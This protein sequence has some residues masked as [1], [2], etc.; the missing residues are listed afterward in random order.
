[1]K[2][3][4]CA[5]SANCAC[6]VGRELLW[7]F[8]KEM[9]VIFINTIKLPDGSFLQL[10]YAVLQKRP[11]FNV[12]F[13]LIQWSPTFAVWWSG[14]GKGKQGHMSGGLAHMCTQFNFH[15]QWATVHVHTHKVWLASW[16]AIH[17]PAAICM[18]AHYSHS[19]VANRSRPGNGYGP[20]VGDPCFNS[21]VHSL[22][23][24]IIFW[25]QL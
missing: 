9:Y 2:N 21:L 25:V 5:E 16:A 11:T 23:A 7:F 13:M 15:E 19:L 20:G 24:S 22:G 3:G 10:Y 1:M 12:L 6:T 4:S 14:R 17:M 8:L 18:L